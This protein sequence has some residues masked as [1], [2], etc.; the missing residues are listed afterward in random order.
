MGGAYSTHWR[1]EKFVHHFSLENLK[2]RDNSEDL[3]VDVTI[4]LERMLG[5]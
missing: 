4:I 1:H 5:K 3:G 2:G